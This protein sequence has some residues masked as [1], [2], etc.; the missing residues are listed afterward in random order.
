MKVTLRSCVMGAVMTAVTLS[1]IGC[2]TYQCGQVLPSPWIMRDD[3]QYFPKGAQFPL[4]NE[5]NSMQQAEGEREKG[6]R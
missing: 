4:H 2:Q 6:I 5:L 1:S 3:P